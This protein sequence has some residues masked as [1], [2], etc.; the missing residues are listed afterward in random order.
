MFWSWGS[1]F[2]LA[3]LV[4]NSLS[5]FPIFCSI[6]FL[7][8]MSSRINYKS[9]LSVLIRDVIFLSLQF[10]S[11]SEIFSLRLVTFS[12]EVLVSTLSSNSSFSFSKD[13]GC[14][15]NKSSGNLLTRVAD[16]SWLNSATTTL[17]SISSCFSVNQSFLTLLQLDL[18]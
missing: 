1:D 11:I 12:D 10:L 18:Y 14:T 2:K 16:K 3:N 4:C 13:A 5:L 8:T 6:F 15:G 7:K 17:P 9:W